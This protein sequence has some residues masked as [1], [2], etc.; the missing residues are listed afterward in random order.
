MQSQDSIHYTPTGQ[1][2]LH[3]NRTVF[4]TQQQDSIHYTPTGQY[5]LHTNRTD[6]L[7]L[8][9]IVRGNNKLSLTG[10]ALFLR[11]VQKLKKKIF[12]P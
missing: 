7:R 2:S 11:D 6:S 9:L 4:T 8:I 5:S 1:Y 10:I 12:S 3:T